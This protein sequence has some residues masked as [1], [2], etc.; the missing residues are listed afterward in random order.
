MDEAEQLVRDRV[1]S[2][3][4]QYPP[5]TTDEAT[6]WGAQ[7]DLG[8]A[9]VHFLEGEGGLE[10]PPRHQEIVEAELQR[11]GAP[12]SSLRNPIGL[13]MAG[14]TIAAHGTPRQRDWWLRPMFTCQEIWSQLFSEPGAGSDVA[15]LATRAVP[16]GGG[17]LVSGQKVWTSYAHRARW[18]LLLART[19]PDVPKHRGLTYFV[20]DLESPGVEVRPLRQMTGGAE[21]SEIYLTD[22]YIPDDYRLDEVGNGWQVAVTTLMSERTAL[23]SSST[24]MSDEGGP[25]VTAQRIW[26]ERGGDDPLLR[27]RLVDLWIEGQALD[28]LNRRAAEKRSAGVPG[29]EGSVAKLALTEF[30]QAVFEWCMD[31]LGDEALL[32]PSYE[33]EAPRRPDGSADPR[34]NFLR[35]R[36]NTIAGG[37]TEIMLN[38]LGERV[39]G[40]P[41]EVRVDK[42][43]PWSELPRS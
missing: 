32:Y 20:V 25:V 17:W 12:D 13:G 14:P 18:G 27:D 28:Q 30:N 16:E 39:L 11:A 26:K 38:I 31:A 2:L 6:F 37:T 1:A 43:T 24:L 22:V 35:S 23:G 36:A 9:W 21:F 3:L 8:L 4:R 34:W 41:S 29:P 5:E 7:F 42:Q 33:V 40:L 15:S 10:L 19:D